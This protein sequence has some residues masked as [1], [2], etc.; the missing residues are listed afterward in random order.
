MIGMG[1]NRHCM[2][3]PEIPMMKVNY[4][5]VYIQ[6][7]WFR[8]L[9]LVKMKAMESVRQ[10]WRAWHTAR[11]PQMCRANTFYVNHQVTVLHQVKVTC[12]SGSA[13]MAITK[14]KEVKEFPDI[15]R[16]RYIK[17]LKKNMRSLTASYLLYMYVHH[18]QQ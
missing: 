1:P 11:G 15:D 5:M 13:F 10:N 18:L 12:S 14:F 3:Q 7:L 8:C 17:C 2:T 16:S 4:G 9:N 6:H